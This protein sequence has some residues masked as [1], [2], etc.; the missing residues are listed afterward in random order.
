MQDYYVV[1]DAAIIK[2]AGQITQKLLQMATDAQENNTNVAQW[3]GK[4]FHCITANL[5][6]VHSMLNL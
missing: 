4:L 6:H 3:D 2:R 1:T 5:L